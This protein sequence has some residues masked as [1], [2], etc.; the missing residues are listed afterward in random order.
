MATQASMGIGVEE[1][2]SPETLKAAAA[3]LIATGLFVMLGVGSVAA[4]VASSGQ[5][6]S[7][8]DGV[9][10]I[11]LTHAFA[12][13]LL[14]AGI[15][16]ISGGHINPAVTFAMLITGRVSVVRGLM[17][18]LAQLIGACIGVLLLRAFITDSTLDLIP[19]AGGEALSSAVGQAWHGMLLGGMGTFVLV[20]TIFAVTVN[21]RTSAG[22]AAPL[23]VG[24]AVGAVYF[25]L[26]P[27]T[28]AGINPARS[29]GAALFLPAASQ[30]LAGR[31]DD[32][33][34]Y[35]IGPLL[36][37]SAAA[38]SYYLLYLMPGPN[39]R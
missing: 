15:S 31:F 30:G 29:L 32:Q 27:L 34:I 8:T 2:S 4:F 25:F 10:I 5:S 26:V 39:E 21:P 20:W 6:T 9:P 7:L 37:S 33:W 28:G 17:Y 19:G 16:G 14:V 1:L 13:A 3:E 11:A 24:L 12:Y 36:G 18:I 22:V 38:L 23:Y 35:W